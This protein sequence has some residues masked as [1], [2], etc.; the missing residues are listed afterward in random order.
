MKKIIA[1]TLFIASTSFAL[2][3]GYTGPVNQANAGYTGPTN[4]GAQLVTV[5]QASKKSD[6]TYI[7]LRGKLVN[8]IK[9]DKFTLQDNT[10][11]IVVEIDDDLLYGTTIAPTDTIEIIGEVD[12]DAPWSKVEIDVKQIRKI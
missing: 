7:T 10:G 6:D 1:A 9:G 11:T 3:D 5:Q 8:H 12:K 2:A 4:A